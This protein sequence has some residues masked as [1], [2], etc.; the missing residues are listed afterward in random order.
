[1][2]VEMVDDPLFRVALDSNRDEKKERAEYARLKRKFGK[3]Q[4]ALPSCLVPAR[5]IS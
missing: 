1:M 4:H 3:R 5:G 2:D